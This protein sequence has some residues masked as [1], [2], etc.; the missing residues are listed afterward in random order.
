MMFLRLFVLMACAA[1]S[2]CALFDEF[3]LGKDNTMPPKPLKPFQPKL[4]LKEVGVKTVGGSAKGRSG[5]FNLSPVLWQG[6]L[7]TAT[8]DGQVQ[9][10]DE[11][12][13]HLVWRQFLAEELAAGPAIN[14][15]VVALSTVKAKVVVLDAKSG[16]L[17]WKKNLSNQALSKP[18]ISEN[19]VFVKTI[20]GNL[21][22]FDLRTGKQQWQNMHQQPKVVL[23]ADSSPV[24][25]GDI[26][27]A[28][29]AD[30]ELVGFN[31]DSGQV[32]WQ[33][34]V[35]SSMGVSDAER[36][37]DLSANPLV[38]DGTLYLGSYQGKV[39]AFN[40][41]GFRTQWSHKMSLYQNMSLG[42]NALYLVDAN[43]TLW[44]IDRH[45][46]VVLWKQQELEYRGLSAP[47][48]YKGHLYVGDRLGY[49]HVLSASSGKVVARVN[50]SRGETQ[51]VPVL[52]NNRLFALNQQGLLK[53]YQVG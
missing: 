25:L 14:Q 51:K 45:N 5:F 27:I 8:S 49:V 17:L 16:R 41:H 39:S 38:D 31:R 47:T 36:M 35:V 30:G 37:V 21:T 43:G 20:D 7:I 2:S 53:V 1:L 4:S 18:L 29:F 52:S 28:G 40:I 19:Q 23:R 11:Q 26:L 22:A 6:R 15:G 42:R 33:K 48:Y 12:D 24:S 10:I 32:L 13:L 34:Q 3:W 9:A 50:P 44:A 46:G